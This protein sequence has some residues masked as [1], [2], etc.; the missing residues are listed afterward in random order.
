MLL[1]KIKLPVYEICKKYCNK[2]VTL[3]CNDCKYEV[4]HYLEEQPLVK[5]DKDSINIWFELQK[6]ASEFIHSDKKTMIIQK[7]ATRQYSNGKIAI[8]SLYSDYLLRGYRN[9]YVFADDVNPRE[10]DTYV[11]KGLIDTESYLI[12]G[13]YY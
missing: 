1:G 12:K 11:V 2:A 3:I 13:Y 5:V 9:M 8:C 6:K 4:L 10:L 7:E